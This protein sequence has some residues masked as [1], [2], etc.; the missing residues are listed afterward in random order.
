[1]SGGVITE[2]MWNG[3]RRSPMKRKPRKR[4]A[5]PSGVVSSVLARD[6]YVCAYGGKECGR[7]ETADHVIPRSVGEKYELRIGYSVNA[8]RNLVAC[9]Q[10][11]NYL[12]GTRLLIP[13]SW[14]E[15]QLDVLNDLGIGIFRV[16]HGDVREPAF[17]AT[18]K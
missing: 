17:A 11:H 1:M 18:W 14:N 2:S 3:L 9:C 10:A 8:P 15:H 5:L 4:T 16:W 13:P 6:R 7:A 12:K